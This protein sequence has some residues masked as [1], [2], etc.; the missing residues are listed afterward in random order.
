MFKTISK[1]VMSGPCPFC[2]SVAFK[3]L[4]IERWVFLCHGC[5]RNYPWDKI[6]SPKKKDRQRPNVNFNSL[7]QF[8]TKLSDLPKDHFC[9][10]YVQARKIPKSRYEKLFFTERMGDLASP[11]EHE[12][13]QNGS[14]YL[15][16]P[17]MNVKGELFGLQGRS[18]DKEEARLRY[19]TLIY[20]KSEDR[21]FGLDFADTSKPFVVLEGPIDSLFLD[22]AVAM[23]GSDGLP[24]KY[25]KNAIVCFDNEPRNRFTVA[26]M[27][28]YLKNGF[29]IVIWPQK[30][31]ENDV[32]DM[33]LNGR[34]V[35]SLITEN[36]Y[37]G[38]HGKIQLD[39]WNKT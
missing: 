28:K 6:E 30:I 1:G 5:Q 3:Y 27:R 14:P 39:K 15:I 4:E 26:K 18:L 11:T 24:L 32:N 37:E 22:N 31:T 9:L 2:N 38:L 35:N 8:C 21:I 16:L 12:N 10:K 29:K 33:V 19:L 25:M 36:I 20:D 23:A 7:L 34:E 17:F 13:I